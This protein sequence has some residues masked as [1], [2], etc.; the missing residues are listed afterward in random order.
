MCSNE[1]SHAQRRRY[2]VHRIDA[3]DKRSTRSHRNQGIHVRCQMEKRSE[4][5]DEEL[6]V[7]DGD[8]NHEEE[9]RKRKDHR[10]L[11]TEEEAGERPSHHMPHGYIEKRHGEDK[12]P[13]EALLHLCIL[14]FRYIAAGLSL[15]CMRRRLPLSPRDSTVSR[16]DHGIH[17]AAFGYGI[18]IIFDLHAV[19][20]EVD[21]DI[22]YTFKPADALLYP[23]LAGSTAHSC[24]I[25]AFLHI[26]LHTPHPRGVSNMNIEHMDGLITQNHPAACRR[27][28]NRRNSDQAMPSVIAGSRSASSP[29]RYIR[30]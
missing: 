27:M 1:I 30:V 24:Y 4:P 11:R 22:L 17:N 20:Q 6:P 28:K 2:L 19:L 3:I 8:R 16:I 14:L 7:Y 26:Q 9:E 13:Y 29:E 21:I 12:R 5:A 15:G 23:D 10:I 18:L 25:E